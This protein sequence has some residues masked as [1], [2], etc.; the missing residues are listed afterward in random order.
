MDESTRPRR[1]HRRRPCRDRPRDC[2]PAGRGGDAGRRRAGDAGGRRRAVRLGM[3]A[4]S[5]TSTATGGRCTAWAPGRRAP[6]RSPTF[7]EV[8]QRDGV[9]APGLACRAASGRRGRRSA[10]TDVVLDPNFPRAAAAARAG[11]HGAAAVPVRLRRRRRRRDGV[12]QP[13]RPAP[14]TRRPA[15]GDDRGRP[16]DRRSTSS[17]SAPPT[18]SSGSSSCRST[19]CASPI[20]TATSCGVNPAWTRVLGYETPS[21]AG[22]PS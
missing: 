9:P 20:S 2:P 11:L 3:R 14:S 1:R 7:V 17:A 15:G 18:S 19:C 10:V 8:S 13:R 16:P 21:C 6:V 5:G 12:L 4:R 22:S